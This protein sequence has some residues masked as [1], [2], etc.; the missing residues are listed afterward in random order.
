MHISSQCSPR[1]FKSLSFLAPCQEKETNS[2]V[3]PAALFWPLTTS[4][5]EEEEEEEET[6]LL[7]QNASSKRYKK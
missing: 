6:K 3:C 4:C 5:E 7:N 2:K 1:L